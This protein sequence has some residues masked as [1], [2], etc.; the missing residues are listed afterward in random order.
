M[1]GCSTS[2]P[3]CKDDSLNFFWS[4]K[5]QVGAASIDCVMHSTCVRSCYTCTTLVLKGRDHCCRL[6][7]SLS[8]AD[9]S[10]SRILYFAVRVLQLSFLRKCTH[11]CLAMSALVG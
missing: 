4:A 5:E 10:S 9:L 8:L 1:E 2:S 11:F 6:S 7:M 3:S